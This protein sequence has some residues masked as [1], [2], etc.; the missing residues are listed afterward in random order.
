MKKISIPKYVFCIKTFILSVA[1]L[2][3]I[4]IPFNKADAK[5][6]YWR[7]EVIATEDEQG[8]LIY[9]PTTDITRNVHALESLLSNNQKKT[10][11]IPEGTTVYLDEV[12]DIGDNTTI[13]ASGASI[14][15]INNGMGLIQHEVDGY[16]YNSLKNVTIIG[17]HWYNQKNAKGTTMFRFMHA[18]NLRFKDVAIDCNY[19]GHALTLVAC[20]NVTVDNCT[21]LAKNNATKSSQAVEEA[22][23]M[24]IAAPNTAPSAATKGKKY[25]NGQT[26]CNIKVVN[27][28]FRGSRGI[29]T[30]IS[31]KYPA[32]YK[33]NY[34]KNIT[35]SNCTINANSSEGIALFNAVGYTVQNN[36]VKTTSKWRQGNH[37]D[38]LHIILFC[39]KK[40]SKKYKNT[41][42]GNTFYGDVHG[43]NMWSMTMAK[44]GKT[45][46]TNNK[47]Y[48]R[49][50]DKTQ[51]NLVRCCTKTTVKK[52][53]I[54]KW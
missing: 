21:M 13:L 4:I 39:Q 14:V 11:V 29:S 19:Q 23:Q 5:D 35:I 48:I 33:K 15:Q 28:T 54:A 26:C 10:L 45:S 30:N 52:N 41:I 27:S 37:S 22:L 2:G 3:S 8:R 16:N 38:A 25:V 40:T 17:G 51:A 24:D 46:V 49:A 44:Y 42:S 50:N 32:L 31:K 20:K 36:V 12:L 43:I 6:Y 1:F 53:R 7:N 47:I 18:A 34:H 9:T